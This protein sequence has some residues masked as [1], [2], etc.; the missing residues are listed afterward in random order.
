M[1]LARPHADVVM[2]CADLDV[3]LDFWQGVFGFTGERHGTRRASVKVGAQSLE[4]FAPTPS[5]ARH[6]GALYAGTGIRVL[7]LLLDD[8]DEACTRLV[9]AGR[10]IASAPPLPGSWPIRFVR[11]P[12]GNM[13]ELIGLPDPARSV[14]LDR[15]QI[16]L[17]VRNVARSRHFYGELL[18]LSE[19]PALAMGEGMTR[20]AF[21]I[22]ESTL[23]FWSRSDSLPDLGGPPGAAL[24]L[25]AIRITVEE[26]DDVLA[27]LRASGVPM[28][29]AAGVPD[30]EDSSWI[31]DP[32]DNWIELRDA[33]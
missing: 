19:Q 7:A 1:Q 4:L 32:D 21:S 15:V 8:L 5:P 23:K 10:R 31:Q 2:L 20:H 29:S 18:G 28:S 26:R 25:R 16:G 11:D 6:S 27:R 13:L 33:P 14:A 9:G 24:G 22:G 3:T 30:L 12:D 17:T